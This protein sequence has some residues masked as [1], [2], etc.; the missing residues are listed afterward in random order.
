MPLT[1]GIAQPLAF[2]R[3]HIGLG[4]LWDSYGNL[5]FWGSILKAIQKMNSDF[6][7]L[8]TFDYPSRSAQCYKPERPNVE[9]FLELDRSFIDLSW[10]FSQSSPL[11]FC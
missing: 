2:A 7:N 3:L 6:G 10:R 5:A 8:G 1:G 4:P 9:W 11:I